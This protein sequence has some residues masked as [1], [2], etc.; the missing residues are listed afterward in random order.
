MERLSI[1]IVHCNRIHYLKA[2]LCSI[3]ANTLSPFEILIYDNNSDHPDK[4]FLRRFE[5]EAKVPVKVF[6]GEENIGVWKA[7]NIL[8]SHAVS[9]TNTLGVIKADNDIIVQTKGWDLKW[10]QAARDIPQIGVI[11]ANAEEISRKNSHITPYSTKG[12]RLL[13]NTDYGTGVCVYL[14]N[15][16]CQNLGYY[17]EFWKMGHCD[18]LLEV[19]CRAKGKWFVYDESVRV[20][21]EKPGRKDYYG[22]YRR[23]KNQYVKN[24]RPLY[25]KFR[26]EYLSGK[27]SPAIWYEKFP[28]PEG[29]QLTDPK[30]LV[31]WE[32]GM[33]L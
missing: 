12:H 23:W 30:S 3:L 5:K 7:S 17:E 22:G 4:R 15:W 25:E 8:L 19:R 16:A 2:A 20:D 31:N 11:G 10:I 14:T 27:R 33:P 32:T 6:Y 26:D 21:R 9:R 28:H 18:K 29:V 13:I 24:N 1:I